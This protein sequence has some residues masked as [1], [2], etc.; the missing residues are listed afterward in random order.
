MPSFVPPAS[1]QS[2]HEPLVTARLRLTPL[3]PQ[4]GPALFAALGDPSVYE[5]IPQNP[6]RS[7]GELEARYRRIAQGSGDS[8]EWW[9]NWAV[10]ATDRSEAPFGTVE[11]SVTVPAHRAVL[12][13]VFGPAAWGHGF[14]SE[15][16]RAVLDYLHE[17]VPGAVVDA[18][19]DTRNVRS[20]ALI[21]RLGFERQET[22][23][24]ADHFKGG[25]SDEF[26]YRLSASSDFARGRR[27]YGPYADSATPNPH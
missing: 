1:P 8:E 17:R 27:R 18:F 22:L 2:R 4:H 23:L 16:C 19:I 15:A 7:I 20:I 6:P 26:R 25:A 10:A 13:Y 9:W 11:F 21:Q 12:G 5:F 3:N 14:A 24:G